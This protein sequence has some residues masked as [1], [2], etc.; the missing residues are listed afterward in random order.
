MEKEEKIVVILLLM[1]VLS[2]MTAY[3]TIYPNSINGKTGQLLSEETEI[4]TVVTIEGVVY[5]KALTRTGEHLILTV[6]YDSWLIKVF[7]PENAGAGE[8]D[9]II[10]EGDVLQITGKL[11]EYK[12][13]KEIILEN[14]NDIILLQNT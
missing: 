7:V 14:K 4:G 12:G 1:A 9:N 6:D 3:L 11:D 10:N 5:E 13:E 8:I 2:L